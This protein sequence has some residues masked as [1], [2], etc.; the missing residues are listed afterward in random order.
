VGTHIVPIV[1]ASSLA[2]I[3]PGDFV[4]VAFT[5]SRGADAVYKACVIAPPNNLLSHMLEDDIVVKF[6]KS[7]HSGKFFIF[8]DQ[9]EIKIVNIS[10]VTKVKPP[11]IDNRGHYYF[12]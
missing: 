10:Q 12:V 4:T 2:Q 8:L 5:T 7:V 6:L 3:L 11:V 1:T 9:D